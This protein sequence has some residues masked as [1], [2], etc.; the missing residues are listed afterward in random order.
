MEDQCTLEYNQP[1]VSCLDRDNVAL[2]ARFQVSGKSHHGRRGP[3]RLVIA[4]THLL[5]NPNR[6]DVKLAQS[7][8]LLAELDRFAA[9]AT[10]PSSSSS[11]SFNRRLPC[12]V[13]G[14]F[15]LTE[16]SP[17]YTFLSGGSLTYQGLYSR[18]L[19]PVG[20]G[21]ILG[22]ALIPR[23]LGITD[24]CKVT[25]FNVLIIGNLIYYTLAL[26]CSARALF[27]RRQARSQSQRVSSCHG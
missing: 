16:N 27:E 10:S 11:S 6:Q 19:A 20:N 1:G 13:M 25:F 8:L 4:N 24:Q 17:V 9:A 21:K 7:V 12:I 15:N 14:D 26:G 18:Q 23:D 2:L 22:S 3:A 5:Y